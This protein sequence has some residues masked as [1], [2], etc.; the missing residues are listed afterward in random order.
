MLFSLV[1]LVS[2]VGSSAHGSAQPDEVVR[3]VPAP[4]T[5]SGS[6]GRVAKSTTAVS[7][8]SGS[9]GIPENWRNDDVKRQEN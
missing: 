7:A 5:G 6:D 1:L 2:C 9:G 3:D 4:N 8:S